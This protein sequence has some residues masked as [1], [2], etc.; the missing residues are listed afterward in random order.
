MIA[1]N[2]TNS[3]GERC[4]ADF[5]AFLQVNRALYSCLNP[6]FWQSATKRAATTE[7]VFMHLIRSNNLARLKHFLEL[8]GYIEMSLPVSTSATAPKRPSPLVETAHLDNIPLARLLL[9]NGAKVNYD[10]CRYSALHAAS[11]SEMVQLLLDHH[12][13]PERQ[14]CDRRQPLH[15][16]AMRDNIAAMR[17]VLQRGADVN[18]LGQW[19]RTPLHEV[20]SADA[21]MLLLEFGA[22]MKAQNFDWET[23]VHSAARRG[24]AEVVRVLVERWPA[25]VWERNKFQNMPLHLAALCGMEE[26]VR[27]LV[28]L[29]PY[30]T[31][32]INKDLN[33]PLHAAAAGKRIQGKAAV[34]RLLVECWPE[35]KQALNK[36]GETPLEVFR[37][38]EGNTGTT[39]EVERE[40]IIALLGG[41][42]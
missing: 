37:R 26:A 2:L 18:P 30:G 6:I 29:G 41:V 36:D 35:G 5:N 9:E 4:F 16:Y 1:H 27:L 15:W 10:E 8:G 33:T 22:V 23:P 28:E 31:R 40:E 42:R 13:D 19:G 12:A 38:H 34:V 7:R 11:S 25:S 3:C 20:R 32:E 17:A 39:D 24:L 14:D 21:A